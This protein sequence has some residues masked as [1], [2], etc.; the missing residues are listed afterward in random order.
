MA[1]MAACTSR[2]LRR[3]LVHRPHQLNTQKYGFSSVSELLKK[4]DPGKLISGVTAEDVENNPKLRAF[5]EANLVDESESGGYILTPAEMKEI[6]LSEADFKND[7]EFADY[8][9]IKIDGGLGTPEQQAL[10][11]RTLH[12]YKRQVEGTNASNRLRWSNVIPGILQGS[13]P[14]S[15]IL[16]N[17]PTSKVLLQTPWT[18]LQRELDRYHRKFE[19]RVYDLTVYENEEDTEGT[20]H[21]VV[22]RNVQRHPVQG[23]IY[24][25]NYLRYHSGRPLKLPI[26]YVNME[27][28]P[29]LK[30]DGYIIPINKFVECIIEDG[31]PIPS[32][33]E[34]ECTGVQIKEVLRLNRIEF[35]DGV[36]PSDRVNVKDF[37]VGPVFGGRSGALD[38]DDD[39]DGTAAKAEGGNA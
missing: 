22:P 30:R 29:A 6:G 12:T 2:I 1:T 26:V 37:V 14:K 10:N 20:V 32:H 27:E 36:R 16:S 15:G 5:M 34:L 9:T 8:D 7:D 21:R 17:D 25:A 38:D 24:C 3:A 23:Q 35:P 18:E 39:E 19:S 28:S 31:V 4:T 33:L 13:D 11:I